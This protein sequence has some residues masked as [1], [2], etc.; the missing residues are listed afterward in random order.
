MSRVA[1][2]PVTVP[3]GVTVTQNGQQVLVEGSKGK[4]AF[5]LHGLVEL[6]QEDGKVV[7]K[8]TSETPEGW[9][10]AGTAR[11]VLNNLVTGVSNGL[12][13]AYN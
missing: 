6:N 11:A 1:K 4:L 13:V 2:A 9:M 10:Q 12:S 7:I 5:N 8:P 3:A